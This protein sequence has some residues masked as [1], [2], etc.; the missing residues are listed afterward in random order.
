VGSGQRAIRRLDGAC[1]AEGTGQAGAPPVHTE[2]PERAIAAWAVT[3]STLPPTSVPS[4]AAFLSELDSVPML[5]PAA[6][7]QW[8]DDYGQ[9]PTGVRATL[10]RPA[11]DP[12]LSA[13]PLH[14]A[15][16]SDE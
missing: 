11:P 10:A 5:S 2:L 16:G 7:Q 6:F 14:P 1:R 13:P 3:A 4:V 8:G 15:A 9:H 12:G